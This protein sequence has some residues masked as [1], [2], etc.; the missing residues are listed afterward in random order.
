[1]RLGADDGSAIGQVHVV[2]E[3]P[4]QVLV[5]VF[6][7]EGG[8]GDL[9]AAILSVGELSAVAIRGGVKEDSE[10]LHRR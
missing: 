6:G 9:D 2:F 10:V 7:E 8:E 1:M 5:V 3:I 4:A